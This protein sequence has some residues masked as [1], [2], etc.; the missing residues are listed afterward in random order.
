ME[1]EM[2]PLP[3]PPL[4]EE[5]RALGRAAVVIRDD[6]PRVQELM[7]RRL[8]ELERRQEQR[9]SERDRQ[10]EEKI[11]DLENRV[12]V[13]VRIREAIDAAPPSH[14]R[15][16]KGLPRQTVWQRLYATVQDYWVTEF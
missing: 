7:Y 5:Q 3:L 10:L 2:N 4:T 11:A 8:R 14:Y 16:S 9:S 15:P 13:I 12:A 6:S 1:D